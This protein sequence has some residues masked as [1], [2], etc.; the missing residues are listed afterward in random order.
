VIDPNAT[1][2]E[3]QKRRAQNAGNKPLKK[4]N[5]VTSFAR[6]KNPYPQAEKTTLERNL[7]QIRDLNYR[8]ATKFVNPSFLDYD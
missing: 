6:S 5:T 7:R 3:K 2:K 1:N 4:L 8:A